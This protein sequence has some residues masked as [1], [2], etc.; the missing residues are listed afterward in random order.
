MSTFRQKPFHIARAQLVD[1]LRE[2]G[3]VDE[4][5]LEAMGRVERHRFMGDAFRERA[6]H[7]AALPIGLKQTI[8]QPLTVATQTSLL[9]V[10]PG[11]RILEI[12]TGS[13]YQAAV[14]CEMGAR[15]FS[16]ERLEPLYERTDPLLRELG[17][18]VRTR[19]GDGTLG[20]PTYAPYDGVVVTAG[21]GE[22][23]PALL[24]QL[25]PPAPGEMRGGRL[26][27]PVGDRSGQTMLRITRI[28][29]GY[30]AESFERESFRTF[31]FVPL[32]SDEHD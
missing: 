16:V 5:V 2:K 12:G 24:E 19:L 27:I 21:A 3:I 23:P 31:H 10:T 1:L 15:V 22:V 20:W 29:P 13:G 14:L 7:D 9:D 11:D 8:S 28:A 30:S 25:R 6:Y 26:V 4:R 17:Y 32:V 18:E